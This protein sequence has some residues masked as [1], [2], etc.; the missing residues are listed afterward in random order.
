MWIQSIELAKL[1]A[2]ELRKEAKEDRLLQ[3][4]QSN[5][6]RLDTL[7]D[8]PGYSRLFASYG[9]S[10]V[11]QWFDMLAVMI[12]FGYIWQVLDLARL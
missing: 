2:E 5:S 4:I 11:G 3:M 6:N 8:I 10:I 1:H 9:I 12:I 7:W